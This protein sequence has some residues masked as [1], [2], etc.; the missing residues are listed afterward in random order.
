[1]TPDTLTGLRAGE[2]AALA[3]LHT[4]LADAAQEQGLLEI[5]YTVISTPVGELLLAATDAGL[6]RV[7]FGVEGHDTVLA[8]LSARIS[9]RILLAPG[10]LAEPVRQLEEYFAGTR[11][12]F[13]LALDFRLATGFRR[14][15]VEHLPDIGYGS[16]ASYAALA[17]LAGSPGAVRAAGTAC[18]RNP[19]P[20]VVPCHR[21]VRSDGKIGNYLGGTDAKA[22]LLAMEAAA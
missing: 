22:T 1:M 17:A 5:A 7:G 9:P 6:V 18:A 13:S 12:D 2:D 4:R 8:Q 14:T 20:V 16:T 21:V 11:R 3:R 15:V 10:R 19:L